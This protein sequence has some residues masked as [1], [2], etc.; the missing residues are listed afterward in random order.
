MDLTVKFVYTIH[1]LKGLSGSF[2]SACKNIGSLNYIE[3]GVIKSE[4]VKVFTGLGFD[5]RN[6]YLKTTYIVHAIVNWYLRY[7]TVSCLL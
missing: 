2:Y 5:A 3:K 1:I 4:G 6:K 7:Y